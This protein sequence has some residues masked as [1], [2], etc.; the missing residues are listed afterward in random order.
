[1]ENIYCIISNLI[2]Y[3]IWHY[4]YEIQTFTAQCYECVLHLLTRAN[5]KFCTECIYDFLVTL[6]I[7]SLKKSK[8]WPS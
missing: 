6:E 1:M 3:I 8:T 4:H 5:C 2:I 7:I